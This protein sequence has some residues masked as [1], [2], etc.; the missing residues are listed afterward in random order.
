MD[1]YISK[2]T[3]AGEQLYKD[4]IE[5]CINVLSEKGLPPDLTLNGSEETKKKIE[6]HLGIQVLRK[7]N[8]KDRPQSKTR[9]DEKKWITPEEFLKLVKENKE[10]V[11]NAIEAAGDEATEE[12]IKEIKQKNTI[13]YCPWYCKK[14]SKIKQKKTCAAIIDDGGF[15]EQRMDVR[16][17]ECKRNNS[18]KGTENLEKM[19]DSI[20]KGIEVTGSP[21]GG[22][23]S[24]NAVAS[25]TGLENDTVTTPTKYIEGDLEGVPAEEEMKEKKKTPR[26]TL[27]LTPL[28]TFG[29]NSHY[30]DY[31]NVKPVNEKEISLMFRRDNKTKVHTLG[32]KFP[33]SMKDYDV[34]NYLTFVEELDEED[35]D[36]ASYV[37][38]KLKI[39]YDFLGVESTAGGKG[40]EESEDEDEDNVDDLLME[41]LNG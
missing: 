23:N 28:S 17:S 29:K 36:I 9:P 12:E 33:D 16:C 7:K 14:G 37:K 39:D 27:S 40:D 19:Y 20:E 4:A 31:V 8:T 25:L 21:V 26:S 34:E 41:V 32:G 18:K 5:N 1:S 10:K 38:K 2:S 35:M 3:K 11:E 13:V 30:T 15:L 6:E 22:V 24:P